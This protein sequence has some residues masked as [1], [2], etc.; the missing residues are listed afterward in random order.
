VKNPSTN[1]DIED[2]M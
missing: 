2:K 1:V